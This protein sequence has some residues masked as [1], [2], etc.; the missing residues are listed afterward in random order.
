MYPLPK[1]F[2]ARIKTQMP[3][4]SDALIASLDRTVQTSVLLNTKKSSF[5]FGDEVVVPWCENGRFLNQRPSFTLDPLFHAGCYYPQESS[6]MF[7]HHVLRNLV[8]EQEYLLALD[9]CAAPGGKSIVLSSFLSNNGIL[10]SNEIQKSRNFILRENLT[11]WGAQNTL[12]TCNDSAAF[13]SIK[14]RFDIVLVDAPCSGE[15]MFRKNEVARKEWSIGNTVMCSNRQKD[16]L[17]NAAMAVK[18]GGYLIYSTCTF[19]PIEN[20][21]VIQW[22]VDEYNFESI[23]IPIDDFPNVRSVDS[24]RLF[25]AKFLPHLVQG[26]GL[27][28]AALRK[29]KNV[30]VIK[31]NGRGKNVFTK[32]TS[33]EQSVVSKWISS[34]PYNFFKNS[35]GDIY[36]CPLSEVELNQL[37]EHL[38]FMSPGIEIG[39]MLKNDFI[40]AHA[41]ALSDLIK[42]EVQMIEVN[43]EDALS[44]LRGETIDTSGYLGW[45]IVTYRNHPLGWIKCML[46]RSNNYYPKQWRIRMKG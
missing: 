38:F 41:L 21:D 37:S 8:F 14:E 15:G 43:S 20:E 23:N 19:A 46:S 44:Y 28:M 10:I 27:F 30:E 31:R 5:I 22:L 3:T 29:P 24:S 25:G 40:P 32:L 18:S 2:I 1:A 11:K 34:T 7:L 6:S 42:S 33:N 35:L 12:I 36:A 26:E 39:R 17:T 45:S 13:G 9:L 4:E 16:I